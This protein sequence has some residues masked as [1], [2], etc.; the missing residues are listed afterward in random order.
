MKA[1]ADAHYEVMSASLLAQERIE[2]TDRPQREATYWQTL[3][4]HVEARFAMLRNW[5]YSWWVSWRA[6]ATFFAPRRY[7]WLVVP[8]R[9]WRGNPLNDAIIDSTGLQ[10]LRICAAGMWSGL[11]N[12]AR[13]W[14]KLDKALPWVEL[15]AETK[16]WI[17]DTEQRLYTVLDQSNFY[18]EMAQAF[19]DLALIG[20]APPL[21][22]EDA[23]DV[24]RVYLPA[25]GEYYLGCGA[26]LDVDTFYR[27]FTFTVLEL[28]EFAG[29]ESCPE[30]IRRQFAAGGGEL[31]VEY[32]VC[33]AIEPNF[34]LSRRGRGRGRHDELRVLPSVFTWREVYW[35]KG[36]KSARPLVLRGF[37]EK[38]FFPMLW[39]RVSNDAYGRGP[40]MDALGD[41][42]QVQLETLR[43]AEFIEKGV[44]PPM[45]ADIELK[46]E[47]ASIAPA[48]ITYMSTGGAAKKFWPLFEPEPQW[49][50]A[51]VQDIA[52]VNARLEKCLYVDVFLAITQMAG[53]Q[54]RN[55]MELTKRDLER[56]QSLGPVIELVEEQLALMIRR[57][58]AIMQR[59][60]MLKPIPPALRGVP[61][62]I[63]F[64]TIMRLAQRAAESIAMKEFIGTVGEMAQ[65]AQEAGVPSPARVVKWDETARDLADVTNFKSHLLWTPAEV[66]DQDKARARAMAASQMP[67]QAM[68]AVEAAK[69]LSQTSLAGGSALSA[70]TGTRGAGEAPGP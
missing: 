39:S 70:L 63:Q 29:L 60:R 12:P 38:P 58:L 54:P 13:P 30:Q 66:L 67:Q 32:V 61:L 26:R 24:I 69:S 14:I 27:E 53:V 44:R 23:E 41:N 31:D 10:A 46:N 37:Y 51:L 17:E 20:T 1:G 59:R 15:D 55:E 65:I 16:A 34:P 45:G 52:T 64:I 25:A 3:Y 22:Y 48:Q 50:S 62:K 33:H 8:N 7:V 9:M 47:P 11:T 40:C 2:A 5:R 42:K 28:V 36:N 18:R 49:L 6:L 43:K 19:H 57:V 21:I 68:A 56:L 35:L 4:D